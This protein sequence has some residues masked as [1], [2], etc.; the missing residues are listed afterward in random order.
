M[1]IASAL[2]LAS[3]ALD[4]LDPYEVIPRMKRPS[5]EATHST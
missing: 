1:K 3:T 2:Y 5:V 4:L